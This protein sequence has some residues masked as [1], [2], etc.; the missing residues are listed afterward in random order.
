[1]I[2]IDT[3]QTRAV[4]IRNA[5]VLLD[6]LNSSKGIERGQSK[7]CMV[8]LVGVFIG[9]VLGQGPTKA[10]AGERYARELIVEIECPKKR[11]YFLA[12]CSPLRPAKIEVCVCILK[13]WFSPSESNNVG[14]ARIFVSNR[15]KPSVWIGKLCN[16]LVSNSWP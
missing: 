16:V 4:V 14:I 13:I 1:M 8:C 12:S 11:E 9:G 5:E 7:L 6:T 15:V 3:S 2:H 10:V